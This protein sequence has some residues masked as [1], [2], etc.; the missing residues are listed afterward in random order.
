MEV[1]VQPEPAAAETPEQEE[2]EPS[3][4]RNLRQWCAKAGGASPAEPWKAPKGRELS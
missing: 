4:P 2:A 3:P 1:E